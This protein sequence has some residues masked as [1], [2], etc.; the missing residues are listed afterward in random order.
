MSMQ[1]EK[2]CIFTKGLDAGNDPGTNAIILR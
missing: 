2:Q 1:F